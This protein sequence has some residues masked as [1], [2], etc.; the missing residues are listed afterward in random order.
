MQTETIINAKDKVEERE[1][2]KRGSKVKVSH[3]T[4]DFNAIVAFIWGDYYL[5]DMENG[6]YLSIDANELYV[7]G[8]A[9]RTG[10]IKKVYKKCEINLGG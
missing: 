5:V 7:G 8:I 10:V 2:I 1:F 4:G 6:Q 9:Q 3:P